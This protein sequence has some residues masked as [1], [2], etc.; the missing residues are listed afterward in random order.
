MLFGTSLER[1]ASF[2]F[3]ASSCCQS[4]QTSER[5]EFFRSSA[6][7]KLDWQIRNSQTLVANGSHFSWLP[8]EA[9]NSSQSWG[10][11]WPKNQRKN[12]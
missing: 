5:A 6:L 3:G 2:E 11:F 8:K 7:G 12:I 1:L 9:R 10:L 4:Y